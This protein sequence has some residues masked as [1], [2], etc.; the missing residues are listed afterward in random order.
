M[1]QDISVG[2]SAGVAAQAK[3]LFPAAPTVGNTVTINSVVYTYGI[4]NDFYTPGTPDLNAF[5]IWSD[6]DKAALAANLANK[7]RNTGGLTFTAYAEGPVLW[8]VARY[9]GTGPNSWTLA[10]SN[11]SAFTVPGTFSGGI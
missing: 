2:A 10:T 9:T 11:T 4:A 5:P 3:I 8:V 6:R 1:Y 7:I